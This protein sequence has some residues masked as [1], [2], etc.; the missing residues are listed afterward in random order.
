VN[1]KLEVVEQ[2]IDGTFYISPV[3]ID[4]PRGITSDE[5]ICTHLNCALEDYQ[6]F[7]LDNGGFETTYSDIEGK[8]CINFDTKEQAEVALDRFVTDFE[9]KLNVENNK[10]FEREGLQVEAKEKKTDFPTKGDNQKITLKNSQFPQFDWDYAINLK[11]EYPEIWK[12]GGNIRGNDAFNHWRKAKQGKFS[13]ATLDWIKEREAWM[14]RHEGDFRIAGVVA[15]MKWG[16]IC[17]KGMSYMKKLINEEKKKIN[18][19]KRK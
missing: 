14:A 19:R 5:V 9:K 11:E 7:M 4:I 6:D 15:V 3:D 13:P 16:G 17:K 18:E 8:N 1:L 2:D 12:K 10:G